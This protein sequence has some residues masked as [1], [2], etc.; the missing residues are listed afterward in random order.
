MTEFYATFPFGTR[1]PI[2]LDESANVSGH[3]VVI[4]ANTRMEAKMALAERFGDVEA[5][6]HSAEQFTP[7]RRAF[8]PGGV[9]AVLNGEEKNVSPLDK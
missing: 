8:Y 9:C 6:I 1:L 7:E 5:H 2:G 4:R 3:Y